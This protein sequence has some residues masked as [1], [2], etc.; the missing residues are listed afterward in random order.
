MLNKIGLIGGGNIGGLL[1]VGI[2]ERRLAKSIALV[3]VKG[4][5]LAVGKTLDIAEGL[6]IISSDVKL[7]GSKEYGVLDGADMVI[8]FLDDWIRDVNRAVWAKG[9]SDEKYRE[10]G[11]TLATGVPVP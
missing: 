8:N 9:Q 3:D 11:T 5:D 1:A 6:P 2:A 4:P 7:E 10:M